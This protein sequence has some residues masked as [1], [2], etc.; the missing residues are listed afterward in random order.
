M[1]TRH[2]TTVCVTVFGLALGP[3]LASLSIAAD[4]PGT[5][6]RGDLSLVQTAGNSQSGT[7]GAKADFTKNW[8]RT[9]FT[10]NASAVRTQAKE[11]VRTATGTSQD[12]F[13]ISE[14]SLTKTSAENYSAGAQLS[15]RVT[16]RLYWFGGGTWSRDIPSGLKSRLMEMTGVGYSLARGDK[17]EFKLQAAATF[18]QEKTGVR[19]RAAKENYPGMRLSYS[20]KQKASENTT[21]THSLTYDQPFSPTNNFRIDGQGGLEVSMTRSGALAL[22]LDA[23]LMYDNMPALEQLELVRPD[24]VKSN[25]RV[26]N[27]LKKLDGQFTVSFVINISRKGGVGR[28]MGR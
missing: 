7:L 16:E 25:T 17:T 22:K 1:S 13:S 18:T 15:Y 8:L 11:S 5:Y 24:G 14:T 28:Q 12:D 6:I 3:G 27:P 9:S 20:Y 19:D 21:L 26:T 10:A 2:L 4:Q 23:R